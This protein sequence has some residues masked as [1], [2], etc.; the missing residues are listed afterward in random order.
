MALV[1]PTEESVNMGV[2]VVGVEIR[3]FNQGEAG[4]DLFEIKYTFM[5]R[6]VSWSRFPLWLVAR[7]NDKPV[8]I[9]W[10]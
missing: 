6:R 10:A 2:Y 1:D 4:F 8:S 5:E 9:L 3:K 7:R